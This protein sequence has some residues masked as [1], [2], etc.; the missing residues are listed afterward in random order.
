MFIEK[1]E[2]GDYFSEEFHIII[3]N[4]GLCCIIAF[5]KIKLLRMFDKPYRGVII[6]IYTSKNILIN[7]VKILD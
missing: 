4:Q 7:L 1:G 5:Y 2:N 6:K 3:L